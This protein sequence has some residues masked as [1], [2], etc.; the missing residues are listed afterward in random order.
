MAKK[1]T[2]LVIDDDKI[3]CN[4]VK[5]RL[6]NRDGYEVLTALNGKDGLKTAKKKMPDLILLDWMMPKMDGME[7]L[8]DLKGNPV[9]KSIKV[10]MFTS[11]NMMGDVDDAVEFGAEG[12]FTKPVDLELLSTRVK[13]TLGG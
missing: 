4:I 8:L 9:T 3:Q 1:K 12:Y 5:A 11:K 2:I 6:G 13:E 7:V 10:F